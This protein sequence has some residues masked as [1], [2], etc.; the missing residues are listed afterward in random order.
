MLGPT[1]IDG[2]FVE[3]KGLEK[4]SWYVFHYDC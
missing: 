2:V 1:S 3:M 4:K